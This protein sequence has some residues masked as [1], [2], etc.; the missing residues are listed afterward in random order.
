[1]GD[2]SYGVVGSAYLGRDMLRVEGALVYCYVCEGY[3]GLFIWVVL[4]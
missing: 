2:W 1:M 4:N 3:P